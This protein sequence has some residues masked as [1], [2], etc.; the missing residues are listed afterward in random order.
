M[1]WAREYLA[2]GRGKLELAV[3]TP[4]ESPN[5]PPAERIFV[6]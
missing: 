6:R 2:I 3:V 4:P 5:H 1:V